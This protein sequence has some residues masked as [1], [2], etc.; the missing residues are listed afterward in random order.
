M[1]AL[2][3]AASPGFAFDEA[4]AAERAGRGFDRGYDALGMRRQGLAV[5]ATGD[6]TERLR[7]L[8][9]PAHRITALVQRAEGGRG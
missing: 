7:S 9:V 1:R 8:R 3:L 2:R 5:V 4:T 6:R